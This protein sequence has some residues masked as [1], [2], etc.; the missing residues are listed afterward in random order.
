MSN[1]SS[2]ITSTLRAAVSERLRSAGGNVA[3]LGAVALLGLTVWV[4]CIA[5]LVALLAPIWGG[6]A[7]LFS[8]ALLIAVIG[9]V[10]LIVLDRRTR[11]Q[12]A[13]A[14]LRQAEARSTGQAALLAAL[15]GLL[16]R[17]SGALVIVSGI[18]VGAMI[19]AALQHEEGG[20]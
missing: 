6:A 12:R 3:I 18:A 7:A 13:R 5:G 16:R 4:V 19:A 1:R 9:L 17:R 14:A 2:G 20:E 8:V 10:L 11:A 15:P